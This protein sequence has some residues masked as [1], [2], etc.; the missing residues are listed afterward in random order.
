M[1]RGEDMLD[2]KLGIKSSVELAKE[3][4]KI[5]KKK[6]VELFESGTLDSLKAGKTESLMY[7]HKAF[8][9][10]EMDRRYYIEKHK[11]ENLFYIEQR[12]AISKFISF[13]PLCAVVLIN[14]IIPFVL[15]GMQQL[16]ISN[17]SL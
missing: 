17:M 12:G 9:D 8:E 3:E 6:A 11:Q 10:V 15:E 16:S 1:K 2:N 14:L 13:I 4:E 5:S 7:I